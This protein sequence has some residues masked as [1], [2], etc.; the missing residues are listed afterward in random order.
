MPRKTAAASAAPSLA[1]RQPQ[2]ID[3]VEWVDPAT[4]HSNDYNPNHVFAPERELLKL[5]LLED[6]WTQPI[7][8]TA[9]GEIVD[10]F[11]RW[12]LG[13]DDPEIRTMSGGQ[14]PVVRGRAKDRAAQRA[15]TVRH[16]R[17][18]GQHGI[19]AMGEIVRSMMAEGRTA[20]QVCVELGM[21]MEELER[22]AD[23]RGSPEM[24]G[25]DSFG[26]GWVPKA[27]AG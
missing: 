5:S 1:D 6:G 21:E 18:R 26:K 14:V 23:L 13:K 27:D 24:A 20:E 3:R 25:K 10:G 7:V 16:N 22:L 17:A 8:A 19:L 2:P 4:L 9:D 11:H 15:S 12:S